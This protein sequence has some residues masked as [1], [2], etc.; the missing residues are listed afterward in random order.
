MFGARFLIQ[1]QLDVCQLWLTH[2]NGDVEGTT[3][4]ALFLTVLCGWE[5]NFGLQSY[6]SASEY[7]L[8]SPLSSAPPH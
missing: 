4:F 5:K 1:K 2:A 7:Y 6:L 3:L 8:T